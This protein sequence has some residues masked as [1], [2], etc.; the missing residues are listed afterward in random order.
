[1]IIFDLVQ[2]QTG[3]VAS[4]GPAGSSQQLISGSRIGLGKQLGERTFVTA[5]AGL[6]RLVST[7]QAGN[8]SF[9]DALGLTVEHRLGYGLTL[10]ASSE[11][12][13]TALACGRLDTRNTPRQYGFDLF[14][15]WTF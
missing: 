6:C 14:R 15:D 7:N 4:Y 11:P 13:S 5:N 3:G 9:V 2:L 1:M 8:S 10:Q 12:S